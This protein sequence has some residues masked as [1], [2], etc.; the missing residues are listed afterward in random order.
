MRHILSI[1]VKNRPGVM[2]HVSGLFTRRGY[3][4]DS[5]AVGVTENPDTSIITIVLKGDDKALVQFQG[6][7]LKLPDVVEVK[8]LPYHESLIRELVL[9]RVKSE[10]G[11]RNEIFG[12]VEVFGGKVAEVTD[13]SVLIELHGSGRQ[14]TA[15][16]KIL[17][18]FGILEIAR[19]G[20]I[21]LAYRTETAQ[22]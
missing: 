7:L 14:I 22:D 5:I 4:I 11:K 10:A 13:D 9:L 8:S 20:Q 1:L 17:A 19:T 12:I 21:A 2:S 15:V 6:Q 16:I 3:N 18:T